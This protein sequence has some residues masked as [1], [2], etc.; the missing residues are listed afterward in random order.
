MKEPADGDALTFRRRLLADLVRAREESA[1][2]PEES[3]TADAAAIASG[4]D[5]THRVAARARA[6]PD[7]PA[8]QAVINCVIGTGWLFLTGIV[9]L[10]CLLGCAAAGSILSM[11]PVNLPLALGG[12]VGLNLVFLSL[13]IVFSISPLGT[14]LY[15]AFRWLVEHPSSQRVALAIPSRKMGTPATADVLRTLA[16]DG[17]A[18][19]LIGSAMHTTWLSFAIGCVLTLWIALLF[20]RYPFSWETTLLNNDGLAHF[21]QVV[22]WLPEK[23]GLLDMR[24]LSVTDTASEAARQAWGWWLVWTAIIYGALPRALAL[25]TCVALFWRSAR[26]IG[27]DL[28]RPGYARLRTRLMPESAVLMASDADTAG[29]RQSAATP[30]ATIKLHGSVHGIGLDGAAINGAPSMDGV[31]WIWLGQVDDAT[32]QRA[33]EQKLTN[34]KVSMLAIVVRATMSPDRGTQRI[35]GELKHAA[36]APVTIVLDEMD[37][38]NARGAEHSRAYIAHWQALASGVQASGIAFCSD[39]HTIGTGGLA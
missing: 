32:S 8:M 2:H 38:L 7:A 33:V 19:W 13:W 10:G 37:V 20:R 14:L 16:A 30:V 9:V 15:G 25:C 1:G 22:S 21:A 5:F 11:R 23:L 29:V 39:P 24:S 31:D 18:R 36:S 3:P 28:D 4:G 27:R 34:K 35:V 6:L 26:N 12:L 17:R